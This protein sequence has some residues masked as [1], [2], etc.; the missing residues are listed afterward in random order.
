[1]SKAYEYEVLRFL[2][3]TDGE[4]IDDIEEYYDDIDLPLPMEAPTVATVSKAHGQKTESLPQY[5]SDW[6]NKA[7][8]RGENPELFFLRGER[9]VALAKAVCQKCVVRK[10]CATYALE[11]REDSGVWGG[12]DADELRRLRRK[13]NWQSIVEKL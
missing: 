12:F 8:C 5:T 3:L 6:R 9:E 13:P 1:M 10:E 2:G 4:I 11:L 7:L